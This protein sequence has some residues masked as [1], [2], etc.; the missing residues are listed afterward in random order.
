MLHGETVGWLVWRGKIADNVAA[1]A[2]LLT[3]HLQSASL[4]SAQ[5]RPG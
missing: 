2:T 4:H 5:S 1:V 3:G